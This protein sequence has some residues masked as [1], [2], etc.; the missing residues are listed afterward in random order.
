MNTRQKCLIEVYGFLR[1]VGIVHTKTDL[2]NFAGIGRTSMSAALNG[3]EAYL[4]D[5]L[6][7]KIH[8]KYPQ[9]NLSYLLHGEGSLLNEEHNAMH[10][11]EE[12]LE[13]DTTPIVSEPPPT[14]LIPQWADSLISIMSS[15]IKENE[16]L[17][18][19]LRHSI[20]KINQLEHDLKTLLQNVQK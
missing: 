12:V 3:S 18:R 1:S 15:Q 10:P 13:H 19:E 17:H 7:K 4:T 11:Y 8:A 9:F 16:A 14:P 20:D 6:F 2:A 5:N